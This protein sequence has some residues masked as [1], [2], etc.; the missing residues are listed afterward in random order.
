MCETLA[1]FVSIHQLP[2]YVAGQLW[3]K[4]IVINEYNVSS[5]KEQRL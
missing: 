2:G 4:I 1:A 3:I 5:Q